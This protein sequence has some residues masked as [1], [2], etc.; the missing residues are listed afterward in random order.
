MKV[1]QAIQRHYATL[2]ISRSPN[3]PNQKYLF[4][5]RIFFGFGLFG[6]FILSQFV[7]IFCVASGLMEYVVC[8]SATSASIIQFVCFAA[9]VYRKSI[10]FECFNK[11]EELID[12]SPNQFLL[13]AFRW[14]NWNVKLFVFIL[15]CK[16]PQS[17]AFF[18]KANRQV[19]RL[20]EI[21][22]IGIVKIALQLIMLS[23]AFICFGIYF[24]TDSGSDSFDLPFP[25]W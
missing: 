6:Y 9:I 18:M 8:I 7:Y 19:E 14:I 12:T 23:K 10:L 20:T 22:F 3:Q 17:E 4:N 15:G 24:T 2:G 13:I 25:M 1:F 5:K 21:I 16:Y 11:T